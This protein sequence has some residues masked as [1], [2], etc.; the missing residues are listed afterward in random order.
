MDPITQQTALA[1]AGAAGGPGEYVDDLFSTY[2]YEGNGSSQTITHGIDIT[3]EGGMTWIKRRNG[4]SDHNLFDTERGFSSTQSNML[5]PN[6][7]DPQLTM[8]SYVNATANGFALNHSGNDTNASGSDYVSWNFR[9]A[10][11]FFDVVTYTG[12]G[13][14]QNISHNLGSVPGMII[15]KNIDLNAHWAV[16]HRELGSGKFLL[17][18]DPDNE[19]DDTSGLYWG[20]TTPTSSVFTVGTQSR[21]N[22][23]DDY[24]VGYNYVAYIFAH[25]D[26]SFGDNGNEAI[27]KCGSYTGTGSAGNQITLGFEPQWLLVK[28]TSQAQAQDWRMFDNMRGVPTGDN[29]AELEPN[30]TSQE[31]SAF[32]IFN[33]N[34]TGFE[35]ESTLDET[36]AS[37]ENFIY[38]AIRRPHKPPSAGT[39]VFSAAATSASTGTKI[40]TGFPVDL[41]ITKYN[42][43]TVNSPFIFTRLTEVSTTSAELGE[44]YLATSSTYGE[45]N[46]T[47]LTRNWG[48]TGFEVPS[49]WGGDS[50]IYWNFRRAP[51]FF[52]VVAYTGDGTSNRQISHNLE[53]TPEM[54]WSKRRDSNSPW[55]VLSSSFPSLTNNHMYLNEGN[56]S[57]STGAAL[58]GWDSSSFTLGT[59]NTTH[60]NHSGGTHI[61][62]LFAS[63]SGISKVG[64]YTGTGSDLDIDCGFTAG[65]RFVLIRRTDSTGGWYIWDSARGIVSGND[66]YLLA[67]STAAEVTNTDYIDPLSAGFTVTSSAPAALNASGGSYIFFA[68]A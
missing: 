1:S 11:G 5:S 54:M 9:K 52:D 3:G 57:I 15:V 49:L 44:G 37:G 56:S 31:R 26:Q 35:T 66:P 36:N 47:T 16:Y 61:A 20:N 2:L 64:T 39:D 55:T 45:F 63:L 67:N 28:N 13:S 14:T 30:Q 32:N 60:Y 33:F 40:T 7:H 19:A 25:D 17:L 46:A 21:V 65:A 53:A 48:N 34:A 42:R 24:G 62:Y 4:T 51:G 23:L 59:Y 41:Q 6:K 27:I 29:S 43:S 10:P 8:S 38:V 18:N 12:T 68:I 50:S 58:S 22:G